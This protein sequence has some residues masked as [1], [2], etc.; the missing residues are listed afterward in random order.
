MEKVDRGWK[1]ESFRREQAGG[2][3]IGSKGAWQI[4]SLVL[5]PAPPPSDLRQVPGSWEIYRQS[6]SL[7]EGTVSLTGS[8]SLPPLIL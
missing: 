2:E 7:L 4:R 8:Q 6:D 5:Q 3:E 1:G